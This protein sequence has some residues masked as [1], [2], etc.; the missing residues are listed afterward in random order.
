[1]PFKTVIFIVFFCYLV[2]QHGQRR[3]LEVASDRADFQATCRAMSTMELGRED[4][5]AIM[6]IVASVLHLGNVTFTEVDGVAA[7]ERP[8]EV[9][10]VAEVPA[11]PFFQDSDKTT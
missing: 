9:A 1:M 10:A 3:D 11:S 7:V 8:Q 4:Q 6:A 2:R 5:D